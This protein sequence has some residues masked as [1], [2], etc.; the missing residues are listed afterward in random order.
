M[1]ERRKPGLSGF[2]RAKNEG[3]F[4]AGCIDSVIDAL[5]ELVVVYKDC[6]DDTE[7]VLVEKQRQYPQKLRVYPYNNQIL[8]HNLTREEFLY[9]ISLSEDS[10][11]LHSSQCNYALSKCTYSHAMKIDP[12]QVYFADEVRRWRDVCAGGGKTRIGWKPFFLLG[13]LFMIL[14][15]LYR[16]LSAKCG[17]PQLW[18]IPDWLVAALSKSYGDYVRWRLQRGGVAVSFSGVNLFY[19]KEWTIPFDKYYIN[20]PY[21]GEGDHLL[22]P[23][24]DGTHFERWYVDREPYSV[25]ENFLHPYRV[26][27]ADHPI[28]FHLHANRNYC[29]ENVRRVKSKHPELFVDPVRFVRMTAWEMLGKMDVKAH[30]LYQ[31]TLF[32]LVHK[33]GKQ[34][35]ENH[36]SLLDKIRI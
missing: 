23:V 4:I 13:W 34:T 17:K 8:S 30:T 32:A 11:R 35:V 6:T 2:I 19:D 28:W 29:E 10:P 21:N 7:Q 12:D 33:M 18:M 14:V 5:D 22:F 25:I 24:S 1:A 15:S 16:R 9:A 27:L 36:L 26:L 20:P 3:R 31:R